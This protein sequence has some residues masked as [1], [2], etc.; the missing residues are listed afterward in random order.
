MTDS[1]HDPIRGLDSLDARPKRWRALVVEHDIALSSVI[2]DT[3]ADVFD[4]TTAPD[5]LL[6]LEA[7]DATF[8]LI[9]AETTG[10]RVSGEQLIAAIRQ[11]KLGDV[12]ILIIS[13]PDDPHRIRL[14]REGAQ[15][16][17]VKPFAPEELRTRAV[18]LASAKRAR[19]ML[20]GE[21]INRSLDLETLARQARVEREAASAAVEAAE[22]ASRAKDD[23]LAVLSHELRTPLNAILG[24]T[25]ILQRVGLGIPEQERAL[26]VIARSARAQARL[27]DDLLDASAMIRGRV[28]LRLDTIG[29]APIL[30]ETLDAVRPSALAKNVQIHWHA[31]AT[32]LVVV[33]DA[34]RLRQVVRNLLV[35]AI[36]FTP[37][38]GHVMMRAGAEPGAV[39]VS[40]EDT[41]IGIEPQFLSQVF[42][43][44]AQAERGRT[45][46]SGGLGLGLAIVRHL[47]GLHG[48]A[49]EATSKGR[50]CGATFTVR[51]PAI[52][53]DRDPNALVSDGGHAAAPSKAVLLGLRILFVEDDTETQEIVRLALEE[54]GAIVSAAVSMREA[55][56]RIDAFRPDLILS[57]IGLP[58]ED[59]YALMRAIRSRGRQI[60]AIALTAYTRPE[61]KQTALAA[62]YW[63]HMAKPIDVTEL[64]TTI[65]AVAAMRGH[66]KE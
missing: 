37:E 17:V 42:D 2:A 18:N 64:V 31:D 35:N 25:S 44:F 43:R 29:L 49:V 56:D 53:R 39:V 59:G 6:G 65:S 9:V 38:G 28:K 4:V 27:V 34:D 21:G 46:G 36:K 61:D 58:E 5:G 54:S 55:L 11:Q 19:E 15:D 40:I 3:L 7:A 57:D 10:P 13:N 41:G 22:R 62:G 48:G 8:D 20:Q 32:D 63:H 50:G 24:W 52:R 12:P 66:E 60:P 16:Y 33:G 23:F 26:E 1:P 14:L 30:G 47:V 45:R 51:L